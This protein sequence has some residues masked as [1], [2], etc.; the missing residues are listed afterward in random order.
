MPARAH[1]VLA[2]RKRPVQARSA[3]SVDAILQA[4]VQVLLSVGKERLTTT[5]VA[6]RA[7]VSVGTLYQYFPNKSALLQAVLRRHL[8]EVRDELE[9]ECLAQRGNT[10]AEMSTAVITAFLAA[11]MR[12]VKTSAALFSV[13]S[14]VDGARIAQQ[15]RQRAT[16]AVAAMFETSCEPLTRDTDLVATMLLSALSGVSHRLLESDTPEKLLDAYRRELIEMSGA[17][18]AT[19]SDVVTAPAARNPRVG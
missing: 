5:R 6:E 7:G 3:A 15:E 16:K 17:Y 12:E 1:I 13:S 10:V 4:T 19:S 11:K 2:P 8:D 9:R 14:D 18:L